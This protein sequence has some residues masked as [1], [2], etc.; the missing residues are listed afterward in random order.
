MNEMETT[1][2]FFLKK[3]KTARIKTERGNAHPQIMQM[4]LHPKVPWHL[5]LSQSC[6]SNLAL[7]LQ[8]RKTSIQFPGR[9]EAGLEEE[10]CHQDPF[11][12][13]TDS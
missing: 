4:L 2:L 9:N 12:G 3:K 5:A 13:I 6:K 8:H 10:A 7:L 1:G 11:W